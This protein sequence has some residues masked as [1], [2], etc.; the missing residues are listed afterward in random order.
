MFKGEVLL[1][2]RRPHRRLARLRHRPRPPLRPRPGGVGGSPHA[3]DR[4]Q[5]GM[6]LRAQEVINRLV[7]YH[8]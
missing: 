6:G 1:A 8:P 3:G 7:S 5:V 2:A 4:S